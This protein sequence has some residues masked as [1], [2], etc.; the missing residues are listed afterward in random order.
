M[1]KSKSYVRNLKIYIQKQIR[2]LELDSH[3]IIDMENDTPVSL[4]FSRCPAKKAK[5]NSLLISYKTYSP[6]PPPP[7]SPFF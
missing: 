4:Q 7:H 5:T 3:M 1:Q 2:R 6:N